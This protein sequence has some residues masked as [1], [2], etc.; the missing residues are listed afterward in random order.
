MDSQGSQLTSVPSQ[1]TP[2]G[3]QDGS[4]ASFTLPSAPTSL[5][6]LYLWLNGDLLAPGIDYN[7][8]GPNIGMITRF[9]NAGN[10]PPDTF[11]ASYGGSFP[12]PGGLSVPA[13]I[14]NGVNAVFT[15]NGTPSAGNLYLWFNGQL[16]TPVLDYTLSGFTVTMLTQF[17]NA[18]NNDVFLASVGTPAGLTVLS[19]LLQPMLRIAGITMQPGIGPNV[20]QYSELIG[21]VNR[22]LSSYNLDGHTVYTSNIKQFPLNSGQKIY[23]IGPG[24]DFDVPRPTYISD[25]TI[26]FPTNPT[27]RR[28]V[29]IM[30]QDE[31]S[32]IAVQ[33]IPGAPSL[34]L[35]YDGGIDASGRANI[36]LYYQPP[37]DYMLEL[38]LWNQLPT[39][40][41]TINDTATF[42]PGYEEFIVNQGG[43]NAANLYPRES[44]LS[45]DARK[46]ASQAYRRIQ[47]S[48]SHSPKQVSEPGFGA[49]QTIDMIPYGWTVGPFGY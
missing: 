21:M 40:F 11:T 1:I 9:P 34:A 47:Q 19:S 29:Y 28:P 38:Y 12:T 42:P 36:Y 33:D 7:L 43:I 48:N 15:L 10:I 46:L 45:P 2:A 22:M 39:G 16:L 27:V 18:A 49:E 4:N 17:P 13:G 32:S 6:D 3:T 14:Q 8:S 5:G 30:D 25:A 37:A 23:T 35:Y 20:D 24:G 31:W 41:V 26:L 44:M